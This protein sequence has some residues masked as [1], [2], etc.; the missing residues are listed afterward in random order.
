M[1]YLL[2]TCLISE[3][4][5]R[6]SEPK[7]VRWI[8]TVNEIELSLSVL[9]LGEI[10]KGIS[11]LKDRVK[12]RKLQLWLDNDLQDRFRDR[13]LFISPEVSITWGKIQ[14]KAERAGMQIPVIDGLIGATAVYYNLTVITRNTKD[15]KMTGAPVYNPWLA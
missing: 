9:T 2:D 8:R 6:N 7:I 13:M 11:K 3:L 4:I 15:I 5:R 14:G 1:K 10:Q 12:A